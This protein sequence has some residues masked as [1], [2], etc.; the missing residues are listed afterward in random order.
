MPADRRPAAS[1]DSGR[2]TACKERQIGHCKIG[3]E[4]AQARVRQQSEARTEQDLCYTAGSGTV[5]QRG[6]IPVNM[7]KALAGREFV[8]WH[9]SRG[10]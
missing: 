5:P 7:R 9:L 8:H 10:G 2:V 3:P 1:L 4:E 6:G